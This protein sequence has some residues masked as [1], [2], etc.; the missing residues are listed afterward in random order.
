M[1]TRH[2]I[3]AG[4]AIAIITMLGFCGVASADNSEVYKATVCGLLMHPDA[5]EAKTISVR[6]TFVGGLLEHTG[7]MDATCKDLGGISVVND[8]EKGI[9]DHLVNLARALQ[10]ARVMSTKIQ[11]RTV[12][13]H[14]VGTFTA[15][16]KSS[17]GPELV[18]RDATDIKIVAW[19]PAMVPLP[20]AR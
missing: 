14:L 12:R 2:P 17:G 20:Q 9:K 19:T 10:R 4:I 15:I 16:S 13:A 1:V 3:G 7:I 8:A 6:A 18:L 5:F 11:L